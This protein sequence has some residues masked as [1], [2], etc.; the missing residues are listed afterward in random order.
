ME[1]APEIVAPAVPD[2]FARRHTVSVPN[3]NRSR[4]KLFWLAG[5]PEEI[6]AEAI[7]ELFHWI[8]DPKTGTSAK[9]FSVLALFRLSEKYP[10]Q[11]NELKIV[12]EDQQ[13]KNGTSFEKCAGKILQ[14]LSI[15]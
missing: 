11:K 2:F 5:I 8:L 14:E 4:A 3:Y 12:T 15:D 13:C 7:D 10:E 1:I 9:R 6:A